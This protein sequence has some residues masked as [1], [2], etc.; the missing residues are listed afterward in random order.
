MNP[1]IYMRCNTKKA[2]TFCIGSLKPFTCTG[3][4]ILIVVTLFSLLSIVRLIED[5]DD[6]FLSLSTSSAP[7]PLSS[8]CESTWKGFFA[9]IGN[10]IFTDLSFSLLLKE[11]RNGFVETLIVGDVTVDV[12]I[13]VV[14]TM[15]SANG[16]LLIV[17]LVLVISC[18]GNFCPFS[19]LDPLVTGTLIFST[20]PPWMSEKCVTVTL[21]FLFE[22]F[23]IGVGTSGIAE[24]K[25]QTFG[26]VGDVAGSDGIADPPFRFS[27][28][29]SPPYC[30]IFTQIGWKNDKKKAHNGGRKKNEM[31]TVRNVK[32]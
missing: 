20:T 28:S 19:T 3:S 15:S 1:T 12:V 7:F 32:R 26:V 16:L 29:L 18:F 5:I 6:K 30:T 2:F 24:G 9:R 25:L 13:I 21:S 17:V 11:L 23:S 4:S 22:F 31:K 8:T 10:E 14:V 27:V